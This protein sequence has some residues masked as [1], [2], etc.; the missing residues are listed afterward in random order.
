MRYFIIGAVG[1]FLVSSCATPYQ[2]KGLGGGYD[3]TWLNPEA[4]SVSVRGNGFT[5]PD[6]VRDIAL[7]QAAEQAKAKGFAYFR[8][9]SEL[10]QSTLNVS[11]TPTQIDTQSQYSVLG[12]TL[13]GSTRST[14]TGGDP[15]VI[16]RPGVAIAFE[17]LMQKPVSSL[18][19][20][21]VDFILREI[22]PKFR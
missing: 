1:L 4:L 22:S 12:S 9:I 11:Q 17:M 10:D 16:F 13:H 3:T 18:D 7:L 19:Y 6:R 5:S 2:A 15:E 21:D 8:I 14:V 20:Y